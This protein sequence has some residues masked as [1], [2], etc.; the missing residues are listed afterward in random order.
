MNVFVLID[1]A[2]HVYIFKY[3]YMNVNE[4][5]YMCVYVY[6]CACIKQHEWGGWLRSIYLGESAM[7]RIVRALARVSPSGTYSL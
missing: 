5:I 6:V 4:Y 7:I 2:V 1:V 3:V